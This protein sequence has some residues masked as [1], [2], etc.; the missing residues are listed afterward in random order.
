VSSTKKYILSAAGVQKKMRRMALEVAEQHYNTAELILLGIPE[1]GMVIA[2][3][4]QALLA[5]LLSGKVVV[6]KLAMDKQNPKSVAL[7][8]LMDCK[9]KAIII[10]DDVANSGKTMLY[11]LKPLLETYPAMIQTLALVE[12]THKSFPIALDYV[13][14]SISTTLDEHIYVE[15]AENEITGAWMEVL[16]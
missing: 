7:E 15:V 14:L 4:M 6:G 9:N 12:R 13:G 16:S 1:S 10:I 5:E 8:P 11:A 3:A 2:H